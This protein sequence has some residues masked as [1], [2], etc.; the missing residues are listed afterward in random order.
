[1]P[2]GGNTRLKSAFGL[3]LGAGIWLDFVLCVLV[4][5]PQDKATLRAV[6]LHHLQLGEYSSPSSHHAK[7]AD[8]L[9][10]MELPAQVLYLVK[11]GA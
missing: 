5:R 1:M 8:Q 11:E 9:V 10:E 3:A 7:H 6:I 4:V 2:L